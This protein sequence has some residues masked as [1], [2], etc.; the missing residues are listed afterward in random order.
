MSP[1]AGER[2][3]RARQNVRTAAERQQAGGRSS[4]RAPLALSALRCE[5]RQ[6]EHWAQY[7]YG[8]PV[9]DL[10]ARGWRED[11]I[12]IRRGRHLAVGREDVVH[13]L[14]VRAAGA[15]PTFVE[16]VHNEVRG[17][18]RGEVQAEDGVRRSERADGLRR[19]S[20][21]RKSN[22]YQV[23]RVQFLHSIS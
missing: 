11:G 23:V 21:S 2:Q 14:H 6:H 20:L 15:Q 13:N 19:R 22:Y 7:L 12:L 5:R 4:L 18:R 16:G 1:V 10:G 3:A 9:L 8:G 17:G